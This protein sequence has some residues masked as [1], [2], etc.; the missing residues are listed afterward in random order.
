MRKKPCLFNYNLSLSFR[1]KTVY[2]KILVSHR[3][4]SPIVLCENMYFHCT[5]THNTISDLSR[6]FWKSPK[7]IPSKKNRSVLI[8]KISSCKT[9]K[10][11]ICKNKHP[12]K[13]CPIQYTSWIITWPTL[14]KAFKSF[15]DLSYSL[16]KSFSLSLTMK[17]KKI[18]NS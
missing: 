9:Q 15:S 14:C 6:T 12:Q 17:N 2:N 11:P 18:E 7:L 4:H 10:S 8:T 5:Y 16:L 1:N 3:V 13:F